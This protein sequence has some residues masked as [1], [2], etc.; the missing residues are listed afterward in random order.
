MVET[1]PLGRKAHPVVRRG[2]EIVA[3][4]GVHLPQYPGGILRGLLVRMP[5]VVAETEVGERVDFGLRIRGGAYFTPIVE[6]E[7]VFF[8]ST[9]CPLPIALFVEK[10]VGLVG[11]VKRCGAERREVQVRRKREIKPLG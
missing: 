2:T 11:R 4:E 10:K 7:A 5:Q 8:F 9:E 1:I 6:A 3:E